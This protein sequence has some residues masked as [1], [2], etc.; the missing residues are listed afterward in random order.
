MEANE[1]TVI[2][3]VGFVLLLS[4]FL[5]CSDEGTPT[6]GT[7][8]HPASWTDSTSRDFHGEKVVTIGLRS[9]RVCHGEDYEGGR[10]GISCFI[11]HDA[12]PHPDG[13]LTAS[14]KHFHGVHIREAGWKLI[15]CQT[16]H[17]FDYSGGSSGQSCN[18]C[19]SG[20]PEACNTCHGSSSNA[21]PPEDIDGNTETTVRGI[22]AHQS[23]VTY[24]SLRFDCDGCHAKPDS[25]YQHDHVD[26]DLPAELHFGSLAKTEGANPQWD[27]NT[28]VD[29]YCH[30]STIS[31]PNLDPLWTVVD[32]SQTACGTC[33]RIPPH[34][35]W[36]SCE[37]CHPSVVGTD[38]TIIDRELH[39]NGNL[40]F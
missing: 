12:Y 34:G 5:G 17:G 22:G 19:H 14:E 37:Q 38:T 31:G 27:G 23:H 21:A 6:E 20:T 15:I 24:S 39:I 18:G 2:W 26:S 9:C 36:G 29:V 16:C 8:V 33:H 1:R 3:I 11:C 40:D 10:S 25:L 13:W 28:C 7:G 4:I 30:G 35:H 32:G